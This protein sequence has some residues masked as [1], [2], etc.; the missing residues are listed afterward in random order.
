MFNNGIK[1]L[2]KSHPMYLSLMVLIIAT[3][4]AFIQIEGA[5]WD[6]TSHLLRRPETFFTPSHTMLYTGVGLLSI[7]AAISATLLLKNKNIRTMSFS[8]ALKLLILG[9]AISL[10]AGPSDY[11][12]HQIFGVDGLLSPTH[13]ILVTGMLINSVAVVLG[14]ARIIVYF[15]TL[16]ERRLIKASMLPAF[17]VMWLTMIWYVYMF[18]LPLSNGVHFNFNLNPTCESLIAIIALPLICSLVFITASRTIGKFG[19]ASAVTSLLLGMNTFANIL[20]SEQLTPFLP[21]YLM[22][23]IPAVMSD[24]ILNKPAI[25]RGSSHILR[26]EVSGII[27]GAIIGSIFYILG[28]PMLP[29]TFAEPLSYTFHSMNDILV[30][31]VKTL[32]LVLV[33]TAIPGMAMGITGAFISIKKIKVPHM[34]IARDMLSQAKNTEV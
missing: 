5:S 12:W 13:L 6:V 8:T 7:A 27:S 20:P 18:A 10:V 23:I 16:R 17:A 2:M 31:F 4:G 24:L 1:G 32:P 29:I 9:S 25:I 28:Y 15:P 19:A 14:F 21:W 26:T 33:F 30:N 34:D 22:L 11:V 3:A